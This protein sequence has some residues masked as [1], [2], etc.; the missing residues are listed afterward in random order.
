[1]ENA[2]LRF[3]ISDLCLHFTINKLY[4]IAVLFCISDEFINEDRKGCVYKTHQAD[5]HT[6]TFRIPTYIVT[7]E[8]IKLFIFY[9][10]QYL[11]RLEMK[12]KVNN[13]FILKLSV[14]MCN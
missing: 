13:K 6:R 2:T 14:P 5:L 12:H 10:Q 7:V 11:R 4:V 3:Y 9:L 8:L 1:M